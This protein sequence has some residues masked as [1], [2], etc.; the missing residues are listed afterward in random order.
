MNTTIELRRVADRTPRIGEEG[1]RA[2]GKEVAKAEVQRFGH[3]YVLSQF[4]DIL[5]PEGATSCAI[6]VDRAAIL[7]RPSTDPLVTMEMDVS[8]DGGQTFGGVFIDTADGQTPLAY[9]LENKMGTAGADGVVF[10]RG[11]VADAIY[12]VALPP[13]QGHGVWIRPSVGGKGPLDIGIKVAFGFEPRAK[14]QLLKDVHHSVA[15]DAASANQTLNGGSSLS[16]ACANVGTSNLIAIACIGW[17]SFPTRPTLDTLSYDGVSFLANLVKNQ[18]SATMQTNLP[19]DSRLYELPAPHTGSVTVSMIWSAANVY[20]GS[21]A[22]ILATGAKQTAPACLNAAGANGNSPTPTVDVTSTTAGNMVIQQV[23]TNGSATLAAQQTQRVSGTGGGGQRGAAQTAA[24]GGTVTMGW[25]SD[26][27]DW[28]T[29]AA[30]IPVAV[31]AL[32]S[33]APFAISGRVGVTGSSR[34]L[35]FS[36]SQEARTMYTPQ[37]AL[38]ANPQSYEPG[39]A[40]LPRRAGLP[41]DLETIFPPPPAFTALPEINQ[42]IGA[43]VPRSYSF[44]V[45]TQNMFTP[46]AIWNPD[47]FSGARHPGLKGTVRQF[48]AFAWVGPL[49]VP[50]DIPPPPP[51]SARGRTVTIC[52]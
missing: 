34:R 16:F 43:A 19:G 21:C 22:V 35:S 4:G 33:A 30:E 14:R 2:R 40:P 52:G 24:A 46:P 7:H 49:L 38:L 1:S 3:T 11:I 50:E 51:G 17:T 26:T 42:R 48:G 45:E 31:V 9:S 32:L 18:Q 8:L 10:R 6:W 12:A 23:A 28:V 25:T 44:A 27:I 20:T 29:A 37:T 36:P 13:D 47:T 5:A 15:F 41:H 39:R